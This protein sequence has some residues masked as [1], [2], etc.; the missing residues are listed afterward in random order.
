MIQDPPK[1]QLLKINDC[2]LFHFQNST[3]VRNRY[4]YFHS[5]I[6]CIFLSPPG[7]QSEMGPQMFCFFQT[8]R[9]Y[10]FPLYFIYRHFRRIALAIILCWISLQ[11]LIKVS[12]VSV[13]VSGIS[14]SECWGLR[15]EQ[16]IYLTPDPSNM[17]CLFPRRSLER[18]RVPTLNGRNME[19][20]RGEHGGPSYS[21]L[22]TQSLILFDTLAPLTYYPFIETRLDGSGFLK[23]PNL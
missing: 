12:G 19:L 18:R 20:Q 2:L 4:R 5:G 23:P 13:Q 17:T 21:V 3:S 7:P 11:F 22:S 15:T 9:T 8:F 14:S 10:W 6:G 1:S 16:K